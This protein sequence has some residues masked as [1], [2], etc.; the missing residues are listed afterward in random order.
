M[1]AVRI[2]DGPVLA[3][4]QLSIAQ[5]VAASLNDKRKRITWRWSILILLHIHIIVLF[6]LPSFIL[7]SILSV[8]IFPSSL[9]LVI[10]SVRHCHFRRTCSV[11]LRRSGLRIAV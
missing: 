7:S 8:A 11:K 9:S 3:V 1:E 4:V 2:E 10:F 5:L 6:F